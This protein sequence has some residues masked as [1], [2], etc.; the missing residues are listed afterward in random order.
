MLLD[1]IIDANNKLSIC[2]EVLK[3]V[4]LAV[5]EYDC[6]VVINMKINEYLIH[7]LLFLNLMK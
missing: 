6:C 7:L 4:V 2:N 5:D 1:S 3:Y